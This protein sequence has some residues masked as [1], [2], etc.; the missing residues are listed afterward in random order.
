MMMQCPLLGRTDRCFSKIKSRP[1]ASDKGVGK[2]NCGA[3]SVVLGE[4]ATVPN[5][6]SNGK[7]G[8]YLVRGP[9]EV[10]LEKPMVVRPTHGPASAQRMSPYGVHVK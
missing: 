4:F 5:S 2:G 6:R 3:K 8:I 7:S 9:E 10:V 1:R